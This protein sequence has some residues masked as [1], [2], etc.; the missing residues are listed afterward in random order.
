MCPMGQNSFGP[1]VVHEGGGHG[2][3]RLLDEYKYYNEHIPNDVISQ[4]KSWRSKDPYYGYNIDFTGDPAKVHWGHYFNRDGYDAVGMYEGA[5]LYHIGVWRPEYMSCMDDN[6]YYF[7]APSREAIVRRIMRASG[8]TFNIETFVK[9][10]KVKADPTTK[11]P[12]YV[13]DFVPFAPPIL[14]E[15][16]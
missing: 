10:D 2:F 14:V 11:A 15:N 5:S 8:S 1:V 6:R 7:N 12:N 4:V 16:W 3:G 9:N 13:E